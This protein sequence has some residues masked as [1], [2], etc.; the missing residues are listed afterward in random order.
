VARTLG[1]DIGKYSHFVGS[2]HLYD[3]DREAAQQYLDEGIQST[4][5]MPPMPLGDPWPSIRKLLDAEH[6]IRHGILIDVDSWSVNGYWA[7]LIRLLQILAASGDTDRIEAIKRQM[8]F[9]RYTP[10]I[11]GR[12][13]KKR[14]IHQPARQLQL[15]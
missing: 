12:K 13:D 1:L 7:D 8:S 5:L 11:D 6:Q 2:L 15:L 10:Y 14:P 3:H 9:A 4:V